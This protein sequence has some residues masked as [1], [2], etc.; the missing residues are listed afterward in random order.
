MA[1]FVESS[2]FEHWDAA[3]NS[4]FA[5]PDLTC[6]LAVGLMGDNLTMGLSSGAPSS[7]SGYGAAF[8]TLPFDLSTD[9]SSAQR[10]LGDNSSVLATSEDP[11]SAVYAVVGTS[12]VGTGVG[13]SNS[14]S[15]DPA[16]IIVFFK[17]DRPNSY[18]EKNAATIYNVLHGK[19]DVGFEYPAVISESSAGFETAAKIFGGTSLEK[20][21]ETL[22]VWETILEKYAQK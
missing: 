5:I 7:T 14:S 21:Q 9:A 6:E 17:N 4:L 10:D 11:D 12:I 19:G 8:S 18:V 1:I 22:D 13:I 16:G 20:A 2:G 15:D 3:H